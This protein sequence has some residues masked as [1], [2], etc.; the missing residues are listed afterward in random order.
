MK[1]YHQNFTIHGLSKVFNGTLQEKVFWFVTLISVVTYTIFK[2]YSLFCEYNSMHTMTD[3][4]IEQLPEIQ[5]PQITFCKEASA[6]CSYTTLKNKSSYY[7]HCKVLKVPPFWCSINRKWSKNCNVQQ[8]LHGMGCF[9]VNPNET[10]TQRLDG[11]DNQL[12]FAFQNVKK[13]YIFVHNGTDQPIYLGELYKNLPLTPAVYH[14]IIKKSAIHRLPEPYESKCVSSHNKT[15]FPG[16]YTRR[17]CQESCLLEYM[18]KKCQAVPDP[19]KPF[20][21]KH[22]KAGNTSTNITQARKCIDAVARYQLFDAK[23][24]CIC[25][26]PCQETIFDLKLEK[27]FDLNYIKIMIYYQDRQLLVLKE[28]PTY[29]SEHFLADV[30]GLTGLL[31]GMSALSLVEV[32]VFIFLCCKNRVC[33]KYA[34]KQQSE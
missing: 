26:S 3:I 22:L 15:Y 8:T 24:T 9:T 1:S 34:R 20:V 31:V 7:P 12:L 29:T 10:V 27:R 33:S 19:W 17:K 2:C 13:L 32:L 23:A 11:M 28:H 6:L 18:Y 5:L 25:P 16:A 14:M 21:P 4:H 30:G